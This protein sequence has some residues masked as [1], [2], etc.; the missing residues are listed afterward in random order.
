MRIC[1]TRSERNSYSETFIADQIAG[2]SQYAEIFPVHSGRLPERDSNDSLL[3]S[4]PFWMMHK[5]VKG[6]T[7][8][9]NNYFGN[10]GLLKFLQQNEIDVVISNY[11]MAAVH[12]MPICSQLNIPLIPIFHGH[13]I[14]DRKLV[15]QYSTSYKALFEFAAAI[16]VVSD[17]MRARVLELGAKP[18]KIFVIPCG[19]NITKFLKVDNSSE[20]LFLAVGRFVEKK[21]PTF[22]IKAFSKVLEKHPDSKLVMIGAHKGLFF[23]CY[24][25]VKDLE[26]ESSVEFPGIVQHKDIVNYFNRASAFVQHSITASNGDME[27]TPVSLLEASASGLPVVSTYHGGIKD[28]ILHG[29]TGYLVDEGDYQSMAQYM[30]SILDCPEMGEVMGS[31]GRDYIATNYEQDKQLHKLFKLAQQVT[32]S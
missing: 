32:V 12:L 21:G 1:I 8:N 24:K 4:I 15:K 2:L 22:T 25:L 9:R 7:G 18:E 20:K 6:I 26:I 10:F 3:A 30:T 11:G 31:K 13:D 27:G 19:V 14:T 17:E 23:E 5:V 29:E 16:V 28:A